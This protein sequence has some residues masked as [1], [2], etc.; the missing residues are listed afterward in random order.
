MTLKEHFDKFTPEFRDSYQTLDV[1]SQEL[2]LKYDGFEDFTGLESVPIPSL[3][4]LDSCN[5]RV[6]VMALYFNHRHV[7]FSFQSSYP[8]DDYYFWVSREV[9][10]EMRKEALKLIPPDSEPFIRNVTWDDDMSFAENSKIAAEASLQV[11]L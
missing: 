6:G 4:W 5:A 1:F 11:L 2:G 3:S 10:H 9:W 7:G 8:N